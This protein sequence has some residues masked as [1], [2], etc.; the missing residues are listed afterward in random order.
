M[1]SKKTN[2]AALHRFGT[3]IGQGITL[4]AV[5]LTGAESVR[6]DGV[7]NGN[8]D[9]EGTLVLGETGTVNGRVQAGGIVV[10]GQLNGDVLCGSVLHLTPGALVNGDVTAVSMVV[11]EG[12]RLN[13]RYTVGG[14]PTPSESPGVQISKPSYR[15]MSREPSG[16]ISRDAHE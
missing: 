2:A 8:I 9:I 16:K 15:E 1:F 12:G 3:I 14:E 7:Y 13:G 6:I 5:T 11:D 10:A 4:E